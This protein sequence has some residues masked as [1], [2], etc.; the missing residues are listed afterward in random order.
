MIEK[1]AINKIRLTVIN[2]AMLFI[3]PFCLHGKGKINAIKISKKIIASLRK[4]KKSSHTIVVVKSHPEEN[5][6]RAS[7]VLAANK[8]QGVIS[9]YYFSNLIIVSALYL[10]KV[11]GEVRAKNLF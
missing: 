6:L 10:F 11:A 9:F 7:K 8:I 1:S 2:S 3:Q 5:S 4:N